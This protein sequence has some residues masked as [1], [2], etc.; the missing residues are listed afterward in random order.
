[1]ITKL[2]GAMFMIFVLISAPFFAVQTEQDGINRVLSDEFNITISF[3]PYSID[4]IPN[5]AYSSQD[6]TVVST[7]DWIRTDFIEIQN[8]SIIIDGE[9]TLIL[10]F[11][12]YYDYIGYYGTTSG[13]LLGQIGEY[14]GE[15][16]ISQ[17]IPNFA[18]YF[19]IQGSLTS[20]TWS[21]LIVSF[22]TFENTSLEYSVISVKDYYQ[23]MENARTADYANVDSFTN[24]FYTIPM[25][26]TNITETYQR[27]IGW[28]QNVSDV[29]NPARVK[30]DETG[31]YRDATFTEVSDNWLFSFVRW[32]IGD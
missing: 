15:G 8:D 28:T 5:E 16:D 3:Q 21:N 31:E 32:I 19:A 18:R 26:A 24:V 23:I 13:Q 27:F 17:Y 10:F 29:I 25:I 14:L 4:F 2:S 9:Y 12:Q 20:S 6:A 1:M 30:D 11:D 7:T 22:Q